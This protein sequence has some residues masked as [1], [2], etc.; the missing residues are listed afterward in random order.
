MANSD[1]PAEM[2]HKAAFDQ[3][4]HYLLNKIELQRMKYLVFVIDFYIQGAISNVFIK[5]KVKFISAQRDKQSVLLAVWASLAI[6]HPIKL[7]YNTHV[8]Y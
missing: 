6:E 7:V 5:P 3:G 4:L 8:Q 2:P 1:D